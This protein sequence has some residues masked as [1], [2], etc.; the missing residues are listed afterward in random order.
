MSHGLTMM[1]GLQALLLSLAR[2]PSR[3]ISSLELCCTALRVDAGKP[4]A[5]PWWQKNTEKTQGFVLLPLND[6]TI[7]SS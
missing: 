6:M 7:V 3:K 5:V 4:L 1:G 2:N